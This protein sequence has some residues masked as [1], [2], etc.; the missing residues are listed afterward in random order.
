MCEQTK[1][2]KLQSTLAFLDATRAFSPP[3]PNTNLAESEAWKEAPGKRK[4]R[5][6]PR[7]ILSS[8]TPGSERYSPVS[9]AMAAAITSKDTEW[10]P[11]QQRKSLEG[12]E[13]FGKPRLPLR[14]QGHGGVRGR[15][16]QPGPLSRRWL[17]N[18]EGAVPSCGSTCG[19][20]A[21]GGRDFYPQKE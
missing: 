13:K 14:V 4:K 12:R 10:S 17:R 20:G 11:A 6:V 18:G 1:L 2:A 8:E 9:M 7:R 16:L 15:W 19:A 21:Q 3:C 5:S